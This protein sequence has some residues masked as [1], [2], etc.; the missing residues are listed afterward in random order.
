MY[1]L[2][3]LLGLSCFLMAPFTGRAQ[4][5]WVDST[6]NTMSL[7]EKIGQLIMVAAYS[8]KDSL[9][10]KQLG[11]SIEKYHIGGIIFFQG[12]PKSQALM[13][14]KYQ[15]KSR[16]PLMIGMD[17]EN[18]VGWRIKPAMEFPNQTLLGAIRDT[19]L[20][21]RLGEAIGQQCRALGIHVNFAPVADINVNPKNPVIGIRSF[22][23]K[24]EE[25]GNRTLQY[26][27]GLQS[28]HVMA[29]AKHFPGHGDTDTDSHFALPLIRHSVARIDT[30]ELYPFK[31]LFE[32]GIPGVMIAHLNVPSYDT[33]NIPAS[34][35]KRIVTGL[36]REKLHFD[37]LCFT[38]A[39]N[40]KGK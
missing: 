10:E 5:S 24:K 34:L 15:Q 36:L 23:E 2:L 12:G 35:S 1:K 11:T 27:R 14:N 30:V 3:L 40:M 13:T 33:T 39:M 6:L 38:D 8:N 16:I 22:G 28:Q 9:Y 7:D 37:G 4:S 18:G 21:Y 26:M 29:V 17:A 20:I 32:A 31:Q 19:N 25:V